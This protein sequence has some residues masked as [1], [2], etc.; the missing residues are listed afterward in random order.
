M[1]G[2]V[3]SLSLAHPAFFGIGAYA[4]A[5]L[6][7]RGALA[8]PGRR[9]SPRSARP[10]WPRSPSAVPMFRLAEH[11]FAIGTLGFAMVDPDR[12]DQLGGVHAR[13][14][15]RDGH[16][17]ARASGHGAIATLPAF[18]WLALGRGGAHDLF[19][20][21]LTTFRL[22]P[23]LPR[24]AGQ[25]AARRPP[26]ASI[27]SSTGCSPSSPARAVA[28]GVG[29]LYAHYLAVLCPE[30]MGS[31]LTVSLLVIVFLGGVGSL[32]GVLSAR[33]SS[34]R[35]PRSCRMAPTWRLVIYGLLLLVIVIRCAGG[36][37]GVL[38]RRAPRVVAMPLLEVR[39][40]TKR[41]LGVTAVDARRPRGRARRAGQ[42]DR[43]E[44]LGQDDALQ[45]RHRLAPAPT[46]GAWPSAGTTSRAPR[47]IASAVSASGARSSSSACS[48]A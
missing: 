32:R 21:G 39:G 40:L 31:G 29:A 1:V 42:P 18:Y 46:A 22:G 44:R 20:H 4:A 9:S 35:C 16:P 34:R 12:R 25:R 3:G 14:A 48:R 13:A 41:F 10:G 30:E 36:V 6:A 8:L 7:T 47:P 23:R 2:H 27:R 28:G 37:S 15:L 45:L 19:Y 17:Q 43:P 24:R 38:R 33:R 26:P 11:T 5:L